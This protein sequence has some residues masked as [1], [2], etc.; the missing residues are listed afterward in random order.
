[1]VL[2]LVKAFQGCTPL[3]VERVHAKD[4]R[5]A[6]KDFLKRHGFGLVRVVTQKIRKGGGVKSG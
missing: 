2:F 5:A 4:Y 3:K 6:R 1:M